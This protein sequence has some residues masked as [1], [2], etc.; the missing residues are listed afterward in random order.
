MKLHL[1]VAEPWNFEGPDGPNLI[2][3][4]CESF[5]QDGYGDWI[6]CT[7]K[8]F[9]IDNT[10][11]TSLLL[12]RRHTGKNSLLSDIEKG[13]QVVANAYWRKNGEEWDANSITKYQS[14]SMKEEIG[15]WLIVSVTRKA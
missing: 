13:V 7:C 11:V 3:A 4:E 5:S 1:S 8:Q 9:E 12:S 14:I 6:V 15:G 2:V 10:A